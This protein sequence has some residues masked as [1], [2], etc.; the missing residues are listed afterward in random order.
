ML[1]RHQPP[2]VDD[3]AS[4]Q[5]AHRRAGPPSPRPRL[6]PAADQQSDVGR[7]HPVSGSEVPRHGVRS[8]RARLS[9]RATPTV[10]RRD[11]WAKPLPAIAWSEAPVESFSGFARPSVAEMGPAPSTDGAV[12]GWARRARAR[13]LRRPD[14]TEHPMNAGH[15]NDER[16]A[17]LRVQSRPG[18]RR[19]LRREPRGRTASRDARRRRTDAARHLRRRPGYRRRAR[20]PHPGLPRRKL[21]ARRRQGR[22]WTRPRRTPRW[23]RRAGKI[24]RGRPADALIAEVEREQN[25]LLVVGSQDSVDWPAS[26]WARR[27]RRSSTRRLARCLVA[28]KRSE[29]DRVPE[30]DRRR[31]R[32]VSGVGRRLCGGTSTG[33]AL[34]RR[35]VARRRP[36][37]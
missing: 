5:P 1:R 26:S 19:R 37:R 21:P 32:R 31:C 22:A 2:R 8:T 12:H 13:S 33:R 10:S 28:R 35:A 36:R 3:V 6:H 9:A 34:R 17:A 25:T 20:Y 4:E 29:S 11:D 18:R 16:P 30:Q 7:D 27:R 24:V 23:P 15:R 14:R